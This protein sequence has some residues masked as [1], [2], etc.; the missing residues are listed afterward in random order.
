MNGRFVR[1]CSWHSQDGGCANG[2]FHSIRTK[3]FGVSGAIKTTRVVCR[4]DSIRAFNRAPVGLHG[5]PQAPIPKLPDSIA[6][7]RPSTQT[8]K[9]I[10]KPDPKC[11]KG[12]ARDGVLD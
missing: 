8:N 4:S 12:G 3:R 6:D 9:S 11:P 7:L 5:L 1:P 10:L 2:S